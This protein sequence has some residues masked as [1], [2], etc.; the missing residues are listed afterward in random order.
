M[1]IWVVLAALMLAG[2]QPASAAASEL[3]QAAAAI[4]DAR[5]QDALK[6]VGQG[7]SGQ[8]SDADWRSYLKARALVGLGQ[9]ETAEATVRDH[10]RTKPSPYA[11]AS[12]VSILTA[13]GRFDAAATEILKLE[14]ASFAYVSRLRPH[15]VEEIVT[16]LERTGATAVRDQ[17]VTR[18]VTGKYTGPTASRVP[19][20]LRLRYIALLLKQNRVEDAAHETE[21]LETPELLTALLADRTYALLWDHSSVAGLLGPDALIA[22]VERSVQARLEQSVISAGDW[23]DTMRALRAINRP[24][25]AVRLGLHAIS[26]ARSELRGSGAALRLELAYA[27]AEMGEAWAARR[28][29]RELLREEAHSDVAMRIAVA[30]LLSAAGDDEGALALASS[31]EGT[32]DDEAGGDATLAVVDSIIACAAHNL[33]RENRRDEALARLAESGATAAAVQFDAFLCTGRTNDATNALVAMLKDPATRSHGILI[34]QL[35]A[36]PLDPLT[37]LRDVR[38]R[39]RALAASDAV[40]AALKPYARTVPLPFLSSTAGVF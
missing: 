19:D 38:Y 4:D 37:D 29:A 7:A 8:S 5:Y 1:R 26:E 13:R 20:G 39:L 27:Y 36:D 32:I 15:T 14:E 25:E 30:Q 9:G 3:D 33:G 2:A 11:W 12:I 17:L 31:L 21:A 40:Q 28:T 6:L 10:Y 35:Y 16:A 22:R 24:K 23:L 34:A 18:L